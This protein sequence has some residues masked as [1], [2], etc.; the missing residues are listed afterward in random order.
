MSLA[1]QAVGYGY[2]WRLLV[3]ADKTPVYAA[4][5]EGGQHLILILS[6]QVVV[7]ILQEWSL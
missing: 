5:G 1:G 7:V 4:K 3:T 6:K 2:C